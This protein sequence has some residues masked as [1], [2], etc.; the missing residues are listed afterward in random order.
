MSL[1]FPLTGKN[2]VFAVSYFPAVDLGDG[3][4]GLGLTDFKI[5]YTLGNV[6]STNKKFYYGNEEIVIP[7]ESYEL[8]DIKQYLKREILRS[9]NAKG[10]ED[11]EFLL[12]IRANNNT[13]RNE[14]KCA[15]RINFTKPRCW[16]FCR[17]VC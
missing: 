10:K 2:S 16:D 11:E 5:Y 3:D 1:T 7:E 17:I 8:R 6:N 13:M 12:V 14:I 4:Y 9:H 15:Y